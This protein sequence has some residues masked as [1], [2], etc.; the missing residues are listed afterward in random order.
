LGH[1]RESSVS[2]VAE[3]TGRDLWR[4]R[5]ERSADRPFVRCAKRTSTFGE[6]DLRAR[7]M[8]AGLSELGIGV[9]TRVLLGMENSDRTLVA[10]IALRELGAILI[11]LMPGMAPEEH[12]F[13]VN[14]CEAE[15]LIADASVADG[16]L[17]HRDRLTRIATVI[18]D[19]EVAQAPAGAHDLGA[20]AEHEP[21]EP[22]LPLAGH[23][24]RSPSLILYTSG[25][26]GRPKG[27]VIPAGAMPS[28]GR[29]YA[30]CFDIRESDNFFLPLPMAHGVG[31][32]TA[33]GVTMATGCMLTI[34][35]RFRPSQF[36]DQVADS[37]ATVS[38]L[39]PAQ[40]NLLVECG[41]SAPPKGQT[42][43]RLVMTH[44]FLPAFDER[45]GIA[46]GLCWGMTETG[47]TSVG[48][49]PG[50][51]G[52]RGEGYVG[53]PMV[54]VEVAIMDEQRNHLAPAADGEICLRHP[55][56]MLEYLNDPDNTAATLVDGWVHSGDRGFVDADGGLFYRGRFKN[57]IKRSGENISPEE[58]E[59]V[60]DQH[61][62][63]IESM[64]VGVADALRTEEVA[65]VVVV[66]G[67]RD[68]AP[69]SIIEHV[70]ASL[71]RW[72]LP[73]YLKVVQEPLPRLSNGKLDRPT[74]TSALDPAAC[75][76]RSA[77]P[78]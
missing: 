27:V 45:F 70:G 53:R 9:G 35:E 78:A 55:H 69:E 66:K 4:E 5:V 73:R 76:D 56:I 11:P 17:V 67:G 52:E 54:G 46:Q 62:D 72:K 42:S 2:T 15:V 13:Q 7:R 48:T 57:M 23:D 31:G 22:A 21:L 41:D 3:Q 50:Y 19:G 6:I 75:W 49:E 77:T 64:V 71:S 12:V 30:K 14:H 8:A 60:L 26:T 34:E 59:S 44:M 36:W 18:L 37:G 63:V 28:T 29:G 43:L 32:I 65:A 1:E 61:P 51:R 47:A 25:S 39:F 38:I 24:A 10:H 68:V 74:V 40:C 20:L 16:L 58:V 33:Q